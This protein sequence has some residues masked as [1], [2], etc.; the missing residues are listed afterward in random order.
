MSM[1]RSRMALL[2]L[3]GLLGMPSFGQCDSE[4]IDNIEVLMISG[5]EMRPNEKD[6]LYYA[7]ITVGIRNKN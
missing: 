6:G 4:L 5:M 2:L 1:K 7:D 3:I